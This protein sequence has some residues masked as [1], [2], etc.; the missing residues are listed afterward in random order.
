MIC[1][2]S[3]KAKKPNEFLIFQK[4]HYTGTISAFRNYK[5]EAYERFERDEFNRLII[6]KRYKSEYKLTESQNSA[7]HAMLEVKLRQ[8]GIA[9]IETMG[10]YKESGTNRQTKEKSFFLYSGD[11]FFNTIIA[12]GSEFEQD[13]ICYAK[14]GENYELYS[15]GPRITLGKDYLPIGS[16]IFGTSGKM[17]GI[18]NKNLSKNTQAPNKP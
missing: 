9:Y 2:A 4:S 18:I 12:L 11:D 13:A 10:I 16:K 1:T 14:P 6:P 15:T 17:L 8:L 7:R 3:F 5:I